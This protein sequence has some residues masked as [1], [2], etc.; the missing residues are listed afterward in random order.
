MHVEARGLLDRASGGLIIA[1]AFIT[2]ILPATRNTLGQTFAALRSTGRIGL[3]PFI[4]AGYPNLDT[5]A[6]ILPELE[7]ACATAV[8]VGFPFSDPIA[9]GPIIQ[10]A[11]THA[12]SSGL[13]VGDVFGMV[14]SVRVNLS[15]PLVAMV[16]F[17]VVFRYGTRRFLDD[18]ASVGFDGLILP[19]LPPPEAQR[20]CTE[21]RHAG[22]DTILLV[23][24]TTPPDRRCEIASLCS[25]FVY[26]LSISGTTGERADLPDDVLENVTQLRSATDRPIC[27]GF[28]IS[29]AGHV[30]RLRGIADGAIVGSA[31]VRRIRDQPGDSAAAIA[32]RTGEL[33]RELLSQV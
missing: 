25:G 8:E 9:D 15:L 2:R 17:S 33:C 6:A 4:P 21:V 11:F 27:V 23:A 3:L 30:A 10:E 28:G 13:R 20:V 24:P 19:D 14:A 26:F 12:L 32:T 29:T 31:F 16:S 22:L 1:A 5:T 7:A 18:A